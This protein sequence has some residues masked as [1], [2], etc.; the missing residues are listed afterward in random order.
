MIKA[1]LPFNI[2]LAA[3]EAATKTPSNA[4]EIHQV[5]LILGILLA[6]MVFIVP[7]KYMLLP[8]VIATCFIPADQRVIIMGLDFTPLRFLILAGFARLLSLDNAYP[9]KLTS[10]DKMLIVWA[11]SGAVIFVIQ[12]ADTKALIYK[13]GI[14]FDTLGLYWIFRKNLYNWD[15]I[16]RVIKI[17]A[18]CAILLSI[19]VAVEWTTGNNLFKYLGAVH[20][21]VRVGRYRCE[22]SFPHSIMLGVFFGSLAPLFAGMA[23]IDNKLLFLGACAAAVFIVAA[24]ASSTPLMVLAVG[25]AGLTVYRFRRFTKVAMWTFFAML[26]FLHRSEERRV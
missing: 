10:V 25:I 23:R 15:S 21:E 4:P 1:I 19:F 22:A 8:F 18:V 6:A 3:T 11:V 7:R 5:T 17:F 16:K 24:S 9:L 26:A 20:T 12:W 2:L 13:C 14:L